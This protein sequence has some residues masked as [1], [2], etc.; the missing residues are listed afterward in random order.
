MMQPD[1][2]MMR[3]A[4]VSILMI[5]TIVA[6]LVDWDRDGPRR[7]LETRIVGGFA[8]GIAPRTVARC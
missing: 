7:P 1:L 4:A 5:L 2:T 8:V 3:L 6:V